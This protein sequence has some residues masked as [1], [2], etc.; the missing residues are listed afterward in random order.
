MTTART[1]INTGGLLVGLIFSASV[2]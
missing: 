2:D 1:T